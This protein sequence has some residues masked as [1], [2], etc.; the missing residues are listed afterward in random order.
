MTLKPLKVFAQ[1]LTS[2]LA[3]AALLLH[4]SLTHAAATALQVQPL[5]YED[6]LAPGKIKS[7]YVDVANPSD[8]ETHIQSVVQGFRQTG[9]DGDLKFFDDPD[10]SA[11]IVPAL[12]DFTLGP[13]EAARVNFTVDPSRL[14][15]GGIYAAIF[16]RTVP[17]DQSSASSFISQSANVGTLLSLTYGT[18]LPRHG[19]IAALKLPFWQFGS[20]IAG[21]LLYKNTD[22]GDR[23]VGFKPRLTM[24]VLPWGHAP[25]L[26][27][28]LVLPGSSREFPVLRAG[29]FAGLLPVTFTDLD[30][31]KS[32][33]RWIFALTG[34]YAWT[35]WVILAALLLA[36]LLWLSRRPRKATPSKE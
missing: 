16:F 9:T 17:P 14:A 11:A 7:G 19:N 29:S 21:S 3:L 12:T 31:H 33:T 20:G 26:N 6:T 4:P 13:H 28:G 32:G 22:S 10:L 15:Q 30:T 27:A 34:W 8:A 25:V 2:M 1:G 5:Q 18:G 23:A 24:R 35:A 36:A